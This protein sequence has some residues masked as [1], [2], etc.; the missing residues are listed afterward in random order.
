MVKIGSDLREEVRTQLINFLQKNVD[1][2]TWVSTDMP[3]IDAEVMEHHLA[4][5]PKHRPMKEKIQDHAPERQ[6]AIAEE[7]DKLLKA[8]FIREVNYPD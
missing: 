2:F 8:R 7:V 3:G 5:D 1:V 6:K 4:V